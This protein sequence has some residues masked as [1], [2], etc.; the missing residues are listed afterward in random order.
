MANVFI[1]GI[2]RLVGIGAFE[3][4]VFILSIAIFYALLRKSQLFGDSVATNGAISFIIAFLI[5]AFTALSGFR[6]GP[7]FSAFFSQGLVILL[8]IIFGFVGASLFY[9]DLTKMLAE[10]F[11]RRTALYVMIGFGIALFV[12]SGS[13]NVFF[14][15]PTG[16]PKPGESA[17]PT[18]VIILSASL[19]I[20]VVILLIAAAVAVRGG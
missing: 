9:P 5:I 3:I 13:I 11:T 4:L 19:I 16:P 15:S 7:P 6:F 20:F 17:I 18:D 12:T 8:F 2:S 10:Q 1:E 14:A